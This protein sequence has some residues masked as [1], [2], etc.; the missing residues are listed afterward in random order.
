MTYIG[1]FIP[2]FVQNGFVNY[3]LNTSGVVEWCDGAEYTFSSG[4][5]YFGQ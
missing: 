4:V 2:V 1:Y 5:S 3:F